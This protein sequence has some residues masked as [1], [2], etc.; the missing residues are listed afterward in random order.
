[1]WPKQ[2]FKFFMHLIFTFNP[3]KRWGFS[4]S[5]GTHTLS[6]KSSAPFGISSRICWETEGK[7]DCQPKSGT[8][9]IVFVQHSKVCRFIVLTT[10]SPAIAAIVANRQARVHVIASP[11]VNC[12]FLGTRHQY[13]VLPFFEFTRH[14]YIVLAESY[15]ERLVISGTFLPELQ[16][17]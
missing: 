9:A 10:N 6:P 2:I 11:N 13:T 8:R 1:M 16:A 12:S 3:H 4:G 7:G 14:Q 5:R 15:S 17:T